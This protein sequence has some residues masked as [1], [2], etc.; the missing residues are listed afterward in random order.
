MHQIIKES[1]GEE[2]LEGISIDIRMCVGRMAWS[3]STIGKQPEEEE[4]KLFVEAG[5][6]FGIWFWH[7]EKD[8]V[9]DL[10]RT[11]ALVKLLSTATNEER[12]RLRE[13]KGRSHADLHMDRRVWEEIFGLEKADHE[14]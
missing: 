14:G 5:K 12:V 3:R 7:G 11:K 13:M 10:R 4:V 9:V 1:N 2:S 6:K 8:E